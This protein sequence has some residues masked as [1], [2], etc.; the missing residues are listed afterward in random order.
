MQGTRA[1]RKGLLRAGGLSLLMGLAACTD[2]PATG[3]GSPG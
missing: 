3:P 2:T 1:A